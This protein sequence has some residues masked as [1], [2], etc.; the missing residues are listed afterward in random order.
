MKELQKNGSLIFFIIASCLFIC[1]NKTFPATDFA[2]KLGKKTGSNK[3]ILG[4]WVT[5]KKD[6]MVE[7]F[8]VN[9]VLYGKLVE[10]TCNHK[11]K[12]ALA[13]HKD[14]KN[15]N[16]KFRNRSWINTIVLY[17]LKSNKEN[18]WSG[19]YIYDLTTGKTYDV[20]VTLSSDDEINVRGYWGIELL[21][22]SLIF[23]RA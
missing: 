23:K 20:S 17:G 14:D 2:R 15:P 7:V 12:K 22:K 11:E 13:D 21:G 10:F 16:P 4:L 5:E 8:E 6:L 9:S 1:S 3:E 19:G 18:K